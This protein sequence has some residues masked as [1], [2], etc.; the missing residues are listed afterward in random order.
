MSFRSSGRGTLTRERGPHRPTPLGPLLKP[1]GALGHREDRRRGGISG[2]QA[3]PP[4]DAFASFAFPAGSLIVRASLIAERSSRLGAG[5]TRP[6]A[7]ARR[8][9]RTSSPPWK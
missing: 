1:P 7:H 6:S 2:P 9:A 3:A 5:T 8:N 4:C